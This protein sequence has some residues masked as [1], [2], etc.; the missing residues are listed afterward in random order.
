MHHRLKICGTSGK[1]LKLSNID[2]S[3]TEDDITALFPSVSVKHVTFDQD[4]TARVVFAN[5]D[6]LLEGVADALAGLER[7]EWAVTTRTPTDI[8]LTIQVERRL[9]PPTGEGAP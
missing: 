3:V 5:K 8:E 1:I 7:V 4:H 9:E 2:R 6:A